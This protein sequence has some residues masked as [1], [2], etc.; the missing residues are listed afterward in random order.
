MEM[1]KRQTRTRSTTLL[2][3]LVTLWLSPLALADSSNSLMGISTDGKLLACSNRDSGS[4]SIIRLGDNA[5]LWEMK[6]GKKPEGV[7]FLGDTHQLAVAIYAEDKIVFLDADAKTVAGRILGETKVFDEPYG[8]VSDATGQKIFVTL[9]YPGQVVQIDTQTRKVEY[10]FD[11]GAFARGIALS[12]DGKRLFVTEYYTA[13]VNAIDIA[14]RKR[15]DTWKGISSENLARQITLHPT[16][17]K[18]Y[19]PH[20]RSRITAAHGSG[21]IFPYVTAMDTDQREEKRRRRL[22]M[23]AFVGARVTANPWEIAIAPDGKRAYVVFSGTND[24]Y[25]CNVIDDDYR[26]LTYRATLSLGNNPRAVRLSPDGK[27]FYVY[28]ALDFQVV[29]YDTKSLAKLRTID[30]TDNPLGKEVL[31]GKRLFYTALQPM[32]SRRWI[33][34]SSCHPDGESDGRTWQN[35]EGLRDTPAMAGIAATHPIHWS[36]DRDEVQDFEF[37]IR[38]QLMQGRGLTR[39]RL[40]PAL[41]K[42]NKGLSRDLDAL[43]IYNNSHGFTLSPH[44]KNGLSQ[45]AKRGKILFL[46]KQTN[47]ASCHK[48]SYYTDSIT[49]QKSVRHDVGTGKADPTEKMGP[50]YDTPTLLGIYRT[51]PYL[52]HGKAATLRDVLT[53]KNPKDR[54]GKTSHLSDAEIADLV[55]FLKALPYE[56][57]RQ[58]K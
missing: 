35:P 16:R 11:A 22:P 8:L 58:G 19:M 2:S 5:K 23:D 57:P 32:A 31:L 3:M 18:A 49:G 56:L 6:V 36:A 24:M 15:V 7:S 12:N 34:C 46:S 50:T 29:V 30:V 38:G 25:V 43:A 48:G 44:A 37:T 42:P 54:H 4:V 45:S 55:T 28:N 52:H 26:E 53:A 17:P 20:I 51:A 40:N 47:C 13:N 33:S 1:L 10:T 39:T 27:H 21:S 9:T 41:G 14:T